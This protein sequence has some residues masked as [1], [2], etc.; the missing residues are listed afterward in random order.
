MLFM[1]SMLKYAFLAGTLVMGEFRVFFEYPSYQ[2]HFIF[3]KL[4]KIF[5][6]IGLDLLHTIIK[7]GGSYQICVDLEDRDRTQLMLLTG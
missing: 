4:T 6:C 3:Y 2:A 7:S 5:N 1:A